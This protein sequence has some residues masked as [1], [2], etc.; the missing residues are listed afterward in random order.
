MTHLRIAI[1][2]DRDL[3]TGVATAAFAA[4][5]FLR[6]MLPDDA[7]YA[8]HAPEFFGALFDKRVGG[9]TVWLLES[10]GTEGAA[11]AMWDGPGSTDDAAFNLP[12]AATAVL[13]AYDQAV[14]DLLPTARHWYLGVLATHPEHAGKGLGRAVMRAGLA[15]AAAD[16]LPAYLETTNARNVELYQGAGWAIEA[17]V[18]EPLPTWIMRGDPQT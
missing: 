5:P 11:L 7:D 14:H 15:R 3:V 4:D 2:E 1:P 12:P 6:F 8:Q 18:E 16:G 10:D 13:T 17:Q 9:G